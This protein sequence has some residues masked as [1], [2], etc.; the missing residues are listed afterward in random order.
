[1]RRLLFVLLT[2]A[3]VVSPAA[4]QG[5][6]N[7][8]VA[9]GQSAPAWADLPGIDGKTHSLADLKGKELVVLVFTTN[10]C[11]IAQRY[12]PR[13]IEF[14]KEV[15][16][17]SVAVVAVNVNLRDEDRLP[18]MKERAAKQGYTFP[19]LFDES[20][21]IGRAY[22]ATVT[23]EFFVLDKERKIAYMG[24]MDDKNAA[25]EVTTRYLSSAVDA[26][27]KGQRP[28]L[29]ETKMRGCVI[30]YETK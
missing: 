24:A 3:V 5:K 18:K 4:A 29:S 9:I 12:E 20:Q 10:H 16:G 7:K 6:F 25:D 17:K 13:I 11:S 15:S 2:L 30:E 28:A 26:L 19:Y 14:A 21:K 27:L 8:A 1:M 23:P 22:G